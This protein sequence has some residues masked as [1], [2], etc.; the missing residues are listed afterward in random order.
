MNR[1]VIVGACMV[2][3]ILSGTATLRAAPFDKEFKV[4]NV[5][6]Q[7]TIMLPGDKAERPAKEG[8][9]YPYGA[10]VKTGR[11]ASLVVILSEGNEIRVLA[12]TKFVADQNAKDA[13]D[14]TI[15]LREG[16]IQ[17][18]LDEK[19]H[20]TNKFTVETPSAICGAI[21]C[22]FDVETEGE[23]EVNSSSVFCKE[24]KVRISYTDGNGKPGEVTL[25]TGDS[26]RVT[27]KVGKDQSGRPIITFTMTIT[28]AD[29][30]TETIT[31]WLPWIG[32]GGGLPESV[33]QLFTSGGT[34]SPVGKGRGR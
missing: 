11:K 12:D 13:S 20:Q 7:C 27:S 23:A 5:V 32:S 29:G 25:T 8:G 28:R 24:G 31:F 9:V 21:G 1:Y 3:A 34:P 2:A 4:A 10:T 19:F 14:K 22:I 17:V 30:K 6:G 18:K 33:T 16:R 15:R 26:I